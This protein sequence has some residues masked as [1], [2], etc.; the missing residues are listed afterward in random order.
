MGGPDAQNAT[1]DVQRMGTRL[2]PPNGPVAPNRAR[3][4]PSARCL[5]LKHHD[6]LQQQCT[7]AAGVDGMTGVDA[8]TAHHRFS[9]PLT[10]V[11]TREQQ[12]FPDHLNTAARY[13]GRRPE[14]VDA[15][16]RAPSL[17]A[18]PLALRSIPRAL[19]G[20]DAT[21]ECRWIMSL[22]LDGGKHVLAMTGEITKL[23]SRWA[24]SG[25]LLAPAQL[26][27]S[28]KAVCGGGGG[29]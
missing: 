18:R 16:P 14:C 11:D 23:V 8:M 2:P 4:A 7:T 22:E 6:R 26:P 21:E 12:T 27:A 17:S 28:A 19:R 20:R 25:L 1:K 10:H 5:C 9:G 13:A 24:S 3:R 15:S 29:Q